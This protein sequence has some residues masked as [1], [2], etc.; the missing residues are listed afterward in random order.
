MIETEKLHQ[1]FKNSTGITT[2]S[3]KVTKG[4]IFFALK[5]DNFDGNDFVNK[6]LEAGASYAVTDKDSLSYDSDSRI[7]RREDTLT[8]LHELATYHRNLFDIPVLA[9]TGSNGKTT[10]KELVHSV[11]S[12]KYRVTCTTG[13]L[14]NHIGVPLTLLGINKETEIAIIEMGASSQGEI[15]MLCQMASPTEGII[16]SIGKAHLEGFGGVEGVKKA[17]GELYTHL[18]EHG[19]TALLNQ[20]DAVL[21]EMASSR[22]GL[23]TIPYAIGTHQLKKEQSSKG[24]YLLNLILNNS[25]KIKTKFTGEYNIANI[26]AALSVGEYYGTSLTSSIKAIEKYIPEN[27]RSQVVQ[28]SRNTLVVDAYNANPTSMEAALDNFINNSTSPK[29]VILGDMLELGEDSLKEHTLVIQ[30]LKALEIDK[31]Y[32]VGLQFANAA[33]ENPEMLPDACFAP[34]YQQ[35]KYYFKKKEFKG[36]TIL[37]KG[38]RGIKLENLIEVL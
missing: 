14:N 10:T 30:K 23:K 33:T 3:R 36:Y 19:G 20:N 24:E 25:L 29:A 7:I 6:A 21:R 27:N 28:T 5:G 8:A 15:S 26:A 1:I 32:L 2:D 31:I 34:D 18:M 4:N 16:T 11:L 13:N 17:K 22:P 35:L 38:S 9:I 12:T 37:I